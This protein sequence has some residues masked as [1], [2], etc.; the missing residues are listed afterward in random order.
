M[1]ELNYERTKL[2]HYPTE[3]WVSDI[4]VPVIKKLRP[5]IKHIWEP[6]CGDGSM[7]KVLK[8]HFYVTSSDIKDYGFSNTHIFDFLNKDDDKMNGDAIV[9]NP[10]Y[11]ADAQKFIER[12]LTNTYN[13]CGLVAMILR[14]E[15]DCAASRTKLFD[16]YPFRTKIVL[17]TR[18]RWI[19][20][21]KGAPRHNYAW[22]VW[23]W[24]GEVDGPRTVSYANRHDLNP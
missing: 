3:S 19:P 12:A 2:D 8:Q 21:S 13:A 11:G 18:P 23:N 5:D 17:T 10:P 6:C 1:G 20:G 14:N 7:S 9:T 15:Y 16:R 22:Y 4:I 24:L